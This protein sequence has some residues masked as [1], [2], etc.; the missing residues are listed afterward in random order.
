MDK[1]TFDDTVGQVANDAPYC[2]F[3]RMKCMG[4]YCAATTNRVEYRG[5]RELI[6]WRC[7]A[8]TCDTASG[9]AVDMDVA[10]K[11]LRYHPEDKRTY[12]D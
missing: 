3:T 4:R 5:A 2:P 11:K 7:M 6:M 10:P 12:L 9:R 1:L 8:W